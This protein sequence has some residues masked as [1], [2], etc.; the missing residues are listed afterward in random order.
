[1]QR[2]EARQGRVGVMKWLVVGAGSTGGYLGARLHG[3]GREIHFLV[4][5]ARAAQLRQ[6]GLRIVSPDGDSVIE[7][8]LVQRDTLAGP[9]DAV[10]LAVK[11]YQLEAAL[12]DMAPAVGADTMILPVL[13]GME[14]LERI[15]TR[16]G[17]DRIVGC[18]LKVAT[19]LSDEGDIVQLNSLQEMAVGELDGRDSA[20]TRALRDFLH[21]STIVT[22]LTPDIRREMWEKWVLLASL[23][24]LTCLMRGPVGEVVA[25]S[26]GGELANSLLDEVAAVVRAVGDAPSSSFLQATRELLSTQGSPLTSSMY[27]DLQQG[28]PVE[29]ENIL[30]DLH[31]HAQRAGIATP[32]L[33]AAYV[34]LRRYQNTLESRTLAPKEHAR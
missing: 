21:G 16:F 22:R 34:H 30:G 24:G 33:Q 10:L 4:R 1:M 3:I 5:P 32:L 27:R 11:G 20:R 31:R 23:G 6:R 2:P 28:R 12:E 18:T 14:H 13:N 19:T 8:R 29:V 15:A 25:C 9:F 17:A 7:P 26:G